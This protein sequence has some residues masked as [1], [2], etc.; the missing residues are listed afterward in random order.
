MRHRCLVAVCAVIAVVALTPPFAAAQSAEPPRTPWGDPDLQGTWTNTTTTPLERPDDLEGKE[1][2]TEEERAERNPES[3]LS[4]ESQSAT[5][6]TGAYNDYWL[7]KGELSLRTSLIVDPANG[8]LPPLMPKAAMRRAANAGA[9]GRD[10]DGPEDRN[11]YER[12]ISRAL[13]GAMMPGFYN[14]NYQILQTPGYLVIL[15]EMIHDARVIP[16][17]GRPHV[18][19]GIRQWLGDSRGQWV[20]NTLVVETTNFTKVNG[21]GLAVFGASEN[22]RLVE[23]FT[24]V[25]ENTIDYQFTLTDPT[26]YAAP[27]TAAI[28]MTNLG[29]QLFEY[30]CHEGNY[31]LQ[32]ILAGARAAERTAEVASSSR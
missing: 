14:H 20:G 24:R 31:G 13:P 7:E 6:P 22:M 19:H 27:W 8:K 15:V 2:L 28:P 4:T 30:A 26:E 10:P 1:L 16:L 11:P 3:G 5:R 21:R 17:D 12:C 18:G 23:R 25:D 9:G 29:G 32:N